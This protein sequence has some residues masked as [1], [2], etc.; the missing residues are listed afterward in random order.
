MR[1]QVCAVQRFD[2]VARLVRAS[3]ADSSF[4]CS[5]DGIL[6]VPNDASPRLGRSSAFSSSQT[7]RPDVVTAAEVMQLRN[8]LRCVGRED[9][10]LKQPGVLGAA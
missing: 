4:V 7:P 9:A 8:L 6:D 1:V 10:D 5:T 3:A 2:R